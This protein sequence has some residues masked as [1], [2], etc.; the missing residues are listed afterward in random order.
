[1]LVCPLTSI[2]HFDELEDSRT[3]L[4][5]GREHALLDQF[6]QSTTRRE[7]SSSSSAEYNQPWRVAMKATSPTQARSGRAIVKRRSSRSGAHPVVRV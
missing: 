2:E 4:I 7:D 1:M 6:D 5:V 3:S